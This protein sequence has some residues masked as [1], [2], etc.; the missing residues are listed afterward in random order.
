MS[1]PVLPVRTESGDDERSEKIAL[2]LAKKVLEGVKTLREERSEAAADLPQSTEATADS[3]KAESGKPEEMPPTAQE[4]ASE[5]RTVLAKAG[6][7]PKVIAALLMEQV[8]AALSESSA[9]QTAR[10]EASAAEKSVR[11]TAKTAEQTLEPEDEVFA[12]TVEDSGEESP[13]DYKG[14]TTA[15]RKDEKQV[16][17]PQTERGRSE[18]PVR[19]KVERVVKTPKTPKHRERS[20]SVSPVM[21]TVP[22]LRAD[23]QQRKK[24]KKQAKKAAQP[25]SEAEKGKLPAKHSIKRRADRSYADTVRDS[26]AGGGG[27]DGGGPLRR[28]ATLR[29]GRT[30]TAR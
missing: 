11:E 1:G 4:V 2:T 12:S 24:E 9:E 22:R 26:A 19:A 29:T 3:L 10:P 21:G 25:E 23:R 20:R 16:D 18:K 28:R 30:P 14:T 5:F 13:L 6:Y 15:A 17:K 7:D 8:G 27:G